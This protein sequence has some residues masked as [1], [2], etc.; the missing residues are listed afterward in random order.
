MLNADLMALFAVELPLLANAGLL[1]AD[2][3]FSFLS[4]LKC[5]GVT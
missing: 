2:A 3:L 5:P 1:A 4:L